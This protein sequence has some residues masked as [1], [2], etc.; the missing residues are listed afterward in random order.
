MEQ[1]RDKNGRWKKGTCGNP[2]GRPPTGNAQSDLLRREAES[3]DAE[4]GISNREVIAKVLIKL[5]KEG[6]P[7]AVREYYD[8]TEGRAKQSME[9][10]GNIDFPAV[11]GF[12]PEDHEGNGHG[13][14]G[15]SKDTKPDKKPKKV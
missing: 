2:N 12:Y 11:V 6:V 10:V 9:V 3:I 7:W 13:D 1:G 8:R 5:A 15:N 14:N 4:A